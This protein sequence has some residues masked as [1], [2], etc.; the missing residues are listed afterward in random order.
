MDA[1]LFEFKSL[2]SEDT[3]LLGRN[4]VKNLGNNQ[5]ICLHGNLGSGKTLFS[6]GLISSI[7]NNKPEDILSPT[8]TYVAEYEGTKSVFHFDLYR[9]KS[10]E[11]FEKLGFCDYLYDK[12]SLSIVE[13]PELIVD[14]LPKNTCHIYIDYISDTQRQIR[15]FQG[16]KK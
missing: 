5:V 7:T 8:F 2:C 10:S 13:W 16:P 15:A 12:D 4:F 3:F 14:A 9:M 6:K 11:E 1:P